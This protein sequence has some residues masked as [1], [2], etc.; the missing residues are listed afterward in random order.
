MPVCFEMFS[1]IE[2]RTGWTCLAATPHSLHFTRFSLFSR[3]TLYRIT[4]S[5]F[6][7]ATW[8]RELIFGRPLFALRTEF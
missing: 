3:L 5:Q 8:Q 1:E 7:A 2:G 4:F 6:L